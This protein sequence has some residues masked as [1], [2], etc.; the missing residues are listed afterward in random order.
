VA[1]AG[2]VCIISI[3]LIES[4]PNFAKSNF[5]DL[6]D[7]ELAKLAKLDQEARDSEGILI[8]LLYENQ[9][10]PRSRTMLA[11]VTSAPSGQPQRDNLLGCT[12]AARVAL[13]RNV[14]RNANVGHRSR[15]A[16]GLS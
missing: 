8:E 6:A 13:L 10:F 7:P 4:T 2:F 5:G 11:P 16:D 15:N 3:P 14:F 9:T 1:V 12:K